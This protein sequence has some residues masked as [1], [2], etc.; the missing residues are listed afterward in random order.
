MDRWLGDGG[1]AVIGAVGGRFERYGAD[2]EG[3]GWS[4]ATWEPTA[5]ACNP[6]GIVQA[7]VHSVLLDAAMNFA[8][9]AGL[10]GRD[11]SQATL[12]MK[13]ETMRSAR[14][15][16]TLTVRGEVV[17][18]ARQVAY[19]EATVRDADGRLVSRSTGTFLLHR[20]E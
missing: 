14:A 8:V 12:E 19:V 15:G 1:M 10:D 3:G 7:G 6:R 20:E 16:E 13:T 2:G 5:L 11:R 4:A 9:N 17:R 18:M